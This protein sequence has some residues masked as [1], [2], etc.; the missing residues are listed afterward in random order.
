M[1]GFTLARRWQFQS[2]AVASQTAATVAPMTTKQLVPPHAVATV[3]LARRSSAPRSNC[4]VARTLVGSCDDRE[5][6]TLNNC[7]F[8][9]AASRPRIGVQETLA[10][11]AV[12][13]WGHA[14]HAQT[15]VLLA[16]EV[17]DPESPV[18]RLKWLE[19]PTRR[20]FRMKA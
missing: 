15:R 19:L 12:E 10:P 14:R 1:R 9:G 5:D 13:H 20:A 11:C 7:D 16:A 6:T 3:A 8:C 17:V 18:S 4:S 2:P